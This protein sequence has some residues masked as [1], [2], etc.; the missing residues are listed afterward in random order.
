MADG[1]CAAM[2]CTCLALRWALICASRPALA[3]GCPRGRSERPLMFS[4]SMVGRGTSTAACVWQRW[5]LGVCGLDNCNGEQAEESQAS[6][7]QRCQRAKRGSVG[8]SD[9]SARPVGEALVKHYH[10]SEDTL[11]SIECIT[12]LSATSSTLAFQT[13]FSQFARAHATRDV[14]LKK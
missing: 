6:A 5:S 7:V 13:S 3:V 10:H 4:D 11:S 2:W 1:G 8:E 12:W 9:G 14:S